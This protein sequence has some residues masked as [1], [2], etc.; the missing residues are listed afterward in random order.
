VRLHVIYDG[1]G[2]IV[3]AA[4]VDRTAPVRARPSADEGAGH[5][6]AEVYVPAEY[7]HDDLAAVCRRLRVDDSGRFPELRERER[8]SD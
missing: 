7:L 2:E 3:A 6:A 1:D 4:Q 8:R 5:R